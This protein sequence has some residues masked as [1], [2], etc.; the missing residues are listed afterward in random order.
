MI[1]S[2][3]RFYFS[4]FEDQ[5]LAAWVDGTLAFVNDAIYFIVSSLDGVL[6]EVEKY[7]S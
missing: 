2:V 1:L 6:K 3:E 7:A 4:Q 5:P